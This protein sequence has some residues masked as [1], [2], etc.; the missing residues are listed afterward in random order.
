M[1]EKITSL[2]DFK[3]KAITAALLYKKIIIDKPNISERI[4]L[5]D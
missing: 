2:N 4:I 5:K 1:D 3:K